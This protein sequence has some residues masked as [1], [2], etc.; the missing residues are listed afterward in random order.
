[1]NWLLDVFTMIL[2]LLVF[3]AFVVLAVGVGA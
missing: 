3:A 2:W 1:M